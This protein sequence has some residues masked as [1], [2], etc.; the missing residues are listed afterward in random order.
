MPAPLPKDKRKLT[1]LSCKEI[2]RGSGPKGPWV[3]YEVE[4][5][6]EAGE[7]IGPQTGQQLRSFQELPINELVEYDVQPQDTDR[8]GRTYTLFPPREP[9][10]KQVNELRARVEKL[11]QLVADLVGSRNPRPESD[12]PE[13]AGDAPAADVQTW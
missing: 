3:M 1:V 5:L 10:W 13:P 7:R 2:H 11:E 8:H 9:L 6:T 12:S 4:A